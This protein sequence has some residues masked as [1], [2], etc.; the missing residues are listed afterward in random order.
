MHAKATIRSS[1]LESPFAQ[2]VKCLRLVIGELKHQNTV[3]IR[4]QK[5]YPIG[6][7]LRNILFGCTTLQ[8][9]IVST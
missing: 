5:I 4:P 7:T 9:E 1:A 8:N 3:G 6:T 2:N